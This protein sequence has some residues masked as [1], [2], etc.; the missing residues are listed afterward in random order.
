VGSRLPEWIAASLPGAALVLDHALAAL[1]LAA[2][3]R[4]VV[5]LRTPTRFVLDYAV[6]E[7]QTG[8]EMVWHNVQVEGFYTLA[9]FFR[10]FH[11]S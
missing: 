11:V 2:C 5:A 9:T 6:E 4:A 3:V 10:S 7:M 8:G 1:A